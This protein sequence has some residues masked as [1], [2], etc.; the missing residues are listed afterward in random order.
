VVAIA[1]GFPVRRL[2]QLSCEREDLRCQLVR[3][4]D[5]LKQRA[6]S[7]DEAHEYR[8]GNS[9]R[10]FCNLVIYDLIQ[11]ES[12]ALCRD[13]LLAD[14]IPQGRPADEMAPSI[15]GAVLRPPV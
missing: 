12:A 15:S 10:Y 7:Y 13:V 2:A 4:Q 5:E 1:G 8:L 11:A 3:A 9:R 14:K 6:V